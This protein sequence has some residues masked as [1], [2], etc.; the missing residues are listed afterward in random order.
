MVH[1]NFCP[2]AKT[3]LRLHCVIYSKDISLWPCFLTLKFLENR[4]IISFKLNQPLSKCLGF[5]M[6]RWYFFY[7][8]RWPFCWGD[9]KQVADPFCEVSIAFY[10]NTLTEIRVTEISSGER[11]V[12]Q[13]GKIVSSKTSTPSFVLPI[14]FSNN[15]RA[16]T[17]KFY[18]A[19]LASPC[20]LL[21]D[22]VCARNDHRYL[23]RLFCPKEAT[24]RHWSSIFTLSTLQRE[25]IE[26]AS[27]SSKPWIC[28]TASKGGGLGEFN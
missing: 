19:T 7:V 5:S 10:Y 28:F 6:S 26:M 16:V 27:G 11:F 13:Y 25:A 15:L 14:S 1:F 24:C 9:I 12:M 20:S 3:L 23:R 18:L 2:Q 22:S 4:I 8:I 21:I 17:R